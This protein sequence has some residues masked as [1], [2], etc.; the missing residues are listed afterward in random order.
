MH[1]SIILCL[2]FIVTSSYATQQ[3]KETF[4]ADG[5]TFGLEMG[6]IGT[7]PLEALYTFEE[8]HM[9]LDS[10]GSCSGNWRGYKGTWEIKN[11]ELL[12]TSLV[13]G[14]CDRNPPSVDPVLFFGKKEYPVK[15]V[16]F[17]NTIKVRLTQNIYL[18]CK[19]VDGKDE[20]T[21]YEYDAMVYEFSAGDFIYKSK[22]TIKRQWQSTLTSC[23]N[24]Q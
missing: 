11:N 9:M 14:A 6:A 3:I 15:A 16:W 18:T 17:N 7:S 24:G 8:I 21:G 2:L 1:K 5:E 20:T 13:K 22:Q 4:I 12:L 10:K 23:S 19:T